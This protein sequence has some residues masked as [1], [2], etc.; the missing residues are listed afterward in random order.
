MQSLKRFV[1]VHTAHRHSIEHTRVNGCIKR[2][3]NVPII[4]YFLFFRVYFQKSF[5]DGK[6]IDYLSVR[7]DVYR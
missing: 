7:R 4:D 5:S 2:T 1:A 6:N 3:F